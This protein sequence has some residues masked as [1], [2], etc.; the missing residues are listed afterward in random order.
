MLLADP[1]ERALALKLVR[2]GEALE[3][4]EAD[5]RPNILTAYLYDLAGAFS[6]FYDALPVL[7]AEGRERVSRLALCDLTGRILRRGLELLGIDT[8]DTM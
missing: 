5:D 4:V 1:K 8:P 2:F 6:V 7:K 3:D